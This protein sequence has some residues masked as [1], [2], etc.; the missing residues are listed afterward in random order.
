MPTISETS[1]GI[2]INAGTGIG[3]PA[4]TPA[5]IVA[6]LNR[7]INAS[8]ADPALKSRYADVG[9]VPMIFT[10]A[11]ARAKIADDIQKWRNVIESAGLKPE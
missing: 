11:E 4:A 2:E 9:A 5:E 10:P 1:P 6:R 3:V 8:L 7:D